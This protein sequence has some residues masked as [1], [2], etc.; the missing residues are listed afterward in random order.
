MCGLF[1]VLVCGFTG[2]LIVPNGIALLADDM[3][4]A[5]GEAYV[6]FASQ[7]MA[8]QALSKHK[9]RMGTRWAGVAGWL[10]NR[11]D[12]S[13]RWSGVTGVLLLTYYSLSFAPN[14]FLSSEMMLVGFA[15]ILT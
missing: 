9:E 11:D 3:G 15:H 1:P 5:S 10:G 4:R 7:M 8:D 13:H 2:L 14:N 12:R 6:Q